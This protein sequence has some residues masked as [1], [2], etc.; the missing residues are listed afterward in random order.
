MRGTQLTYNDKELKSTRKILRRNLTEHERLLWSKLRAR[1]L[2][3]YK[4]YRQYSINRFVVDFCCPEKRVVIE[5][6]GGHHSE[7]VQVRSD[8]ERDAIFRNMGIRVL[9][10]WNH[11]VKSNLYGVLETILQALK[12]S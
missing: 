4:F 9:R 12:D 5:L 2:D 8:A 1:Q 7:D 10:F 11:E 6:D 3:G